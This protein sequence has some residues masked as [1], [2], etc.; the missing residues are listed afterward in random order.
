MGRPRSARRPPRGLCRAADSRHQR[1]KKCSS[2][3]G[4]G[5][6]ASGKSPKEASQRKSEPRADMEHYQWNCVYSRVTNAQRCPY[7]ILRGDS[8]LRLGRK[9]AFSIAIPIARRATVRDDQNPGIA[10]RTESGP[11][12]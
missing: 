8:F 4:T 2:Q 3:E 10:S 1:L 7:A 9:L 5:A 6:P 12:S 11:T